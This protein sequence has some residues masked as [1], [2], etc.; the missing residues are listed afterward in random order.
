MAKEKRLTEDKYITLESNVLGKLQSEINK[1]AGDGY[2]LLGV[3]V[4]TYWQNYEVHNVYVASMCKIV[5]L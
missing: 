5:P 4:S 1:M 2:Q 3:S